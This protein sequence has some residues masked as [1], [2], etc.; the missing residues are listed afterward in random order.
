VIELAVERGAQ[1]PP[2]TGATLAVAGNIPPGS[3]LSSSSALVVATAL[4][5]LAAWGLQASKHEVAEMT[6]RCDLVLQGAERRVHVPSPGK[7]G[8]LAQNP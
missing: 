7:G 3:G 5:L 4:A 8:E 2:V 1:L 6:A